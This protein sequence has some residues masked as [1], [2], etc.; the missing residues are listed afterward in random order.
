MLLQP[1]LYAEPAL[2]H[3]WHCSSVCSPPINLLGFYV[4]LGLECFPLRWSVL[5][6]TWGLMVLEVHWGIQIICT[7]VA[8]VV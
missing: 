5:P 3:L 4:L 2:R 8:D 7:K 1:E 6:D